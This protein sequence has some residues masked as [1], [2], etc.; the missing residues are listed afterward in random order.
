MSERTEAQRKWLEDHPEFKVWYPHG[1]ISIKGW[2]DRGCIT[3]Q[4]E[5]VAG[6]TKP[7]PFM[8]GAFS[9]GD[10]LYAPGS[11]VMRVGREYDIC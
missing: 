10:T 5:F 4:G 8:G 3:P 11:Y 9:L 7:I 1:F 6:E 2:T